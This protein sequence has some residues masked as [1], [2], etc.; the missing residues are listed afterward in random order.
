VLAFLDDSGRTHRLFV[1]SQLDQAIEKLDRLE[2]EYADWG[3]SR[4]S[5]TYL[6]T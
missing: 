6:S 5:A 3:V 2:R 4:W 1:E